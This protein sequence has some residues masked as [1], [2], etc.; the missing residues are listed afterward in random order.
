M[1]RASRGIS[2]SGLTT[3]IH[4]TSDARNSSRVHEE[5]QQA[6]TGATRP[7]APASA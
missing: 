1:G 5:V 7:R 6:A 4:T 3:G 2:G